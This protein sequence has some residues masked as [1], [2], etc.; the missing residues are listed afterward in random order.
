MAFYRRF[1]LFLIYKLGRKKPTMPLTTVQM[2]IMIG[3]DGVSPMS[4][5]LSSGGTNGLLRPAR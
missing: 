5:G 3:V 1:V 4:A 2:V